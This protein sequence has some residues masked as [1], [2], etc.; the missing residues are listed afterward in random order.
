MDKAIKDM[1]TWAEADKWLGRH[2]YGIEQ[3]REQKELWDAA[4]APVKATATPA[5]AVITTSKTAVTN[6][7]A[8]V[9]KG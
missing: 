9:T 8:T 7:K 2:G 1:K 5:K 6:T 3:I 4:S